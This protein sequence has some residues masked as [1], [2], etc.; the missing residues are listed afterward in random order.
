MALGNYGH[1]FVQSLKE[2]DPEQME[3]LRQAAVSDSIL[4]QRIDA[5]L[6]ARKQWP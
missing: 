6:R 3:R 5:R 4:A 1:L 2:N